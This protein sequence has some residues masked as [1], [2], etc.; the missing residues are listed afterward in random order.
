[1]SVPTLHFTSLA[2]ATWLDNIIVYLY[3]AAVVGV[4]RGVSDREDH[5]RRLADRDAGVRRDVYGILIRAW[6]F[7]T[8]SPMDRPGLP[9]R[10]FPSSPMTALPRMRKGHPRIGLHSTALAMVTALA[11][12]FL[13]PVAGAGELRRSAADEP[14]DYLSQVKPILTAHRVSCHGAAK[15]RGGLRLDTAAGGSPG[16]KG[17]PAVLPGKGRRARSSSAAGEGGTD[18]MPLNRPPLRTEEI[19][20][21]ETWIEQGAKAVAGEKPGVPPAK[22]HWAFVAPTRPGVPEVKAR[23]MGRNPIDR[24]IQAR[25]EEAG[26]RPSAEADRRR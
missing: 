17:G 12:G 25:L 18:R 26:H 23:G 24:F 4:T 2:L 16:G 3:W 13:L 21:I 1:M 11:A 8:G 5:R 19:K 9:A 10:R 14:V 15:P 22:V 7:R 6:S 20:L